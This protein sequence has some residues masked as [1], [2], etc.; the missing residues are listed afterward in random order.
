MNA[1]IKM[2][3][4]IK[5]FYPTT[6]SGYKGYVDTDGRF[7]YPEQ[8]DFRNG[9]VRKFNLNKDKSPLKDYRER[10]EYLL[11]EERL[12][13]YTASVPHIQLRFRLKYRDCFLVDA[14]FKGTDGNLYWYISED[15]ESLYENI[16]KIEFEE[17]PIYL[18][19]ACLEQISQR[20]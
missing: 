11:K 14:L 19:H 5:A 10:A 1:R 12:L 6:Q 9:G 18:I 17:L 15:Y 2:T 3:G 16:Q 4:E 7:Y 8:L 20:L 13:D